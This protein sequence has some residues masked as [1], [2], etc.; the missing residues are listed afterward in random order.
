[1]IQQI[2]KK[3]TWGYSILNVMLTLHSVVY[4]I[5]RRSTLFGGFDT[6]QD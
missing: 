6:E 4:I 1:M 2:N 5:S 3:F